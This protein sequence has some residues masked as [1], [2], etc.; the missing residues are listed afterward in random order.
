MLAKL[1]IQNFI[2]IETINIDFTNGLNIIIGETGSGK[3]LLIDALMLLFGDKAAVL[4]IRSGCNKAVIEASF[5][6][7]RNNPVFN[8]LEKM[9]IDTET[10]EII[11]RREIHSKGNSRCFINDSPVTLAALKL[12]TRNLVDF[13]GQNEQQ[14]I[15]A[16]DNQLEIIDKLL[17][18]PNSLANYRKCFAEY[19]AIFNEHKTLVN[20]RF[21]ADDKFIHINKLLQEINEIQPQ[22]NEDTIID[23]ELKILENAEYL[24]T[25]TTAVSDILDGD[26]AILD[27]LNNA[28]KQLKALLNI[29]NG[30][31]QY[32]N[33]FEQ[34]IISIAETANY[35]NKYKSNIEFNAERIEQL[36]LRYTQ[37]RKLT[38]KYG[39]LETA[40]NKKNEYENELALLEN[41]DE[42][43]DILKDKLDKKQAQL[44]TIADELTAQ[45]HKVANDFELNIVKELATLGIESASFNV[46]F[47]PISPNSTGADA[48]EFHISANKGEPLA[49]L[50][51]AASGG[52]ISRIMLA[53]KTILAAND[54][55]P[56]LI[57]DEIDTGISGRIAQKVGRAMKGLSK[58]HQL[59]AITHLPQIAAMADNMLLIHKHELND[60]V[61]AS[62]IILNDNERTTELAKMLSGENITDA[63][64]ESAKQLIIQAT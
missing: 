3:S 31:A 19:T 4:D 33:E 17:P 64:I 9:E 6:F 36:R 16:P 24:L 23:N 29:D 35:I 54:D 40:I 20:N 59:L 51:N 52:E 42:R 22:P 11:I 32:A 62:A 13:H 38:K 58:F 47:S 26:N 39:N 53:I 61:V 1:H 30:F 14:K 12:F 49:P 2:I 8:V 48:I 18:N 55:T 44:T 63:A 60:R 37:L 5:F 41:Y 25:A 15:L 46:H 34:A 7:E 45:R 27:N 28:N 56:L 21:K 50:A 57:F 43:I 10:N